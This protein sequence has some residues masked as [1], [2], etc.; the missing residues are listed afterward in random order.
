[1]LCAP[2]AG[3]MVLVNAIL[4]RYFIQHSLITTHWKAMLVSSRYNPAPS[5]GLWGKTREEKHDLT[6]ITQSAERQNNF[7]LSDSQSKVPSTP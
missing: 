5:F 7:S 6:K 1:M 3:F 4:G 2:S